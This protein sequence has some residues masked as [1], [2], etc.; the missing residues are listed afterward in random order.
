MDLG[1]GRLANLA[2]IRDYSSRRMS[3]WVRSTIV[4]ENLDRSATRVDTCA[5]ENGR[6]HETSRHLHVTITRSRW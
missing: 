3:S 1:S 4:G 2:R 6:I 5:V